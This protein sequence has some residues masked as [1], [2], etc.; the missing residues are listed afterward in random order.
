MGRFKVT[1]RFSKLIRIIKS[2]VLYI[3]DIRANYITRIFI[4]ST[5]H[6]TLTGDQIK[7]NEMGRVY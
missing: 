3:T 2:V 5:R 6:K 1:I 4:N 7:E